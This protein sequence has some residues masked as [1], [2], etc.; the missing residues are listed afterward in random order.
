MDKKNIEDMAREKDLLQNNLRKTQNA[1]QKQ[2]D[3][4]KVQENTKKNLESEIT[5]YKSDAQ[6]QRKMIYALEKEREKYG[7][8]ASDATAK[9]LEALEEVKIRQMTIMDLQKTIQEGEQKLKQQQALY[10]AVRSDRNLYSKNLIEAQDEIDEMRRKFKIMNH[11]IEQLKE[12]IQV[13]SRASQALVEL[14]NQ[15]SWF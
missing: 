7:Q 2:A 12:E 15:P 14:R 4:V 5:G 9:Y 3:L 6:K 1:T 8:Q 10:E 11:Q 13:R